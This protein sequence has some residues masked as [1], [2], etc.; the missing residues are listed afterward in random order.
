LTTSTSLPSEALDSGF[1]PWL[2]M[3]PI[4]ASMR[5]GM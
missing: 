1:I 4:I 3:K 2:G 5:A